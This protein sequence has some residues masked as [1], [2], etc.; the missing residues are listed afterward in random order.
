MKYHIIFILFFLS[1]GACYAQ[2][3]TEMN[4]ASLKATQQ[5]DSELNKVYR[6]VLKKYSD[7]TAFIKNFKKAQRI[8]IQLR[9]AE[10]DAKFP[11]TEPGFYGSILPL[12]WNLYLQ[13]LTE[14]RIKHLS[15]WLTGAEEGDGCNG[16]IR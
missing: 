8:W 7:D 15:V 1:A 4:M 11:E 16:S 3:Q 10:M 12:C 2:T 5:A 13:E 6:A 14:M 9:D